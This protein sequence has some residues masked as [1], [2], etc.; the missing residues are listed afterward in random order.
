M[1]DEKRESQKNSNYQRK[2]AYYNKKTLS[3]K[4]AWQIYKSKSLYPEI[5]TSLILG[6]VLRGIFEELIKFSARIFYESI[7]SWLWKKKNKKR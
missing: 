3:I 6:M 7:W 5:T 2:K 4:E 1:S